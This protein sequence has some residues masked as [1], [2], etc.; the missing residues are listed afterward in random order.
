[1][2][3]RCH[4]SGFCPSRRAILSVER[5]GRTPNFYYDALSTDSPF[6]PG[7]CLHFWRILVP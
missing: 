4:P 1:M 2:A 3:L 6:N 7:G 5:L